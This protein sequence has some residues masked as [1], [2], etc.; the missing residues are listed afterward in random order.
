MIVVSRTN[1]AFISYSQESEEHQASVLALANQLRAEG[2]EA[3]I[4]RYVQAPSEGWPRWIERQI[5]DSQFV[6]CVCSPLYRKGF[7]GRNDG[8]KGLGVNHEGFLVLQDLYDR[9]N[10]TDKYLAVVF[11]SSIPT[12]LQ[13]VDLIPSPLRAFSY[14]TLPNKYGEFYRRLTH[15]PLV[16]VPAVGKVQRVPPAT[17]GVSLPAMQ[18]QSAGFEQRAMLSRHVSPSQYPLERLAP[19]DGLFLSRIINPQHG[20]VVPELDGAP[21]TTAWIAARGPLDY[22]VDSVRIRHTVAGL[23][24]TSGARVAIVPDAEYR[25]TYGVSTDRINALNPALL[26]GPN[27][28][29]W[30]W[31]T[32]SSTMTG[33]SPGVNLL[34]MWL[35]YHASDGRQGTVLLSEVPPDGA[36]L[37][38]LVGSDILY[39]QPR[40]EPE[41]ESMV[42]TPDGLQ[43]GL[44]WDYAPANWF[45]AP[46][47]A[48]VIDQEASCAR[49][50][51]TS[52][53]GQTA[54]ALKKRAALSNVLRG[55]SLRAQ[56]THWFREAPSRTAADLIGGLADEEGTK[57]L[58][59]TYNR[60]MDS[61]VADERGN[62]PRNPIADVAMFG[63]MV[64]HVAGEDDL[65]GKVIL[66][67]MPDSDGWSFHTELSA[68]SL[69][70][71]RSLIDALP[72][73]SSKTARRL[74]S[75]IADDWGTSLREVL[76][77]LPEGPA[78]GE[79]FVCGSMNGWSP[80]P[81][82]RLVYDL[83][84][85]YRA[86]LTLN[87]GEY[88]LKIAGKKWYEAN[89]G[90]AGSGTHL[91]LGRPIEVVEND[92]SSNLIVQIPNAG[93]YRFELDARKIGRF[94]LSCQVV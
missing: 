91:P 52:M 47:F 92:L 21:L 30:A 20:F 19:S 77:A 6:I 75:A 70:P 34:S 5:V 17:V 28:R 32:L 24:G 64:R 61:G 78:R 73:L 16:I 60:E 11:S 62:K 54:D 67:R 56:L 23:L 45:S 72:R 88:E 81:E 27:S 65:L 39:S 43:R 48:S 50:M 31:F 90:A 69:R 7:E 42:I 8:L 76:L 14:Y 10:R 25:F 37:A 9:G 93:G 71:T 46:A 85:V 66:E 15:Q 18:E 1:C 74:V 83:N 49:R 36:R 94:M 33:G 26:V 4:D 40:R 87:A 12:G 22:V 38:K 29:S 68:L 41:F 86:A 79:L 3:M 63:L 82:G 57:Q 51:I 13:A 59:E 55:Q 35:Q 58:L 44:E 84:G 2:V 53:R 89:F 80:L